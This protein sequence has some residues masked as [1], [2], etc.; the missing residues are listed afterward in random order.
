MFPRP[1]GSAFFSPSSVKS[2]P[3]PD[4][5]VSFR[6]AEEGIPS[7]LNGQVATAVGAIN[8]GAIAAI[9]G[10]STH[11][12]AD[13]Y[14]VAQSV[15]ELCNSAARELLTV[16]EGLE[17]TSRELMLAKTEISVQK[18]ELANK[19]LELSTKEAEIA[20]LKQERD[21][22]RTER[23]ASFAQWNKALTDFNTSQNQLKEEQ[24]RA[25]NYRTMLRNLR[26]E[27]ETFKQSESSPANRNPILAERR[28]RTRNPRDTSPHR[29]SERK[30]RPRHRSIGARSRNQ[31]FGQL[32][33]L[34]V[35][36]TAGG[37]PEH[38]SNHS[39]THSREE[40]SLPHTSTLP[41]GVGI[42]PRISPEDFARA[43]VVH[44]RADLSPFIVSLWI[45]VVRLRQELAIAFTADL[46]PVVGV[47]ASWVEEYV[48]YFLRIVDEAF[49]TRA[50]LFANLPLMPNFLHQAA[51]VSGVRLPHSAWEMA[52]S[53]LT[54]F[55]VSS[56]QS[57]LV[58]FLP[59]HV[60]GPSSH[61]ASSPGVFYRTHYRPE[62]I[63]EGEIR[64]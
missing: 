9:Q 25:E 50:A 53:N 40:R 28:S 27:F 11:I 14:L 62:T 18:I 52:Q 58:S 1:A 59:V 21:T 51:L 4:T 13:L 37:H 5:Q 6:P 8:N 2:E 34:A 20:K 22:A 31:S 39:L 42:D 26:Q 41:I 64:E 15:D 43:A 46:G 10:D 61:R 60:A 54:S 23:N 16:T 36:D 57:R 30:S 17:D 63:E 7:V 29:N 44:A 48:G 32:S 56:L 38:P 24:S 55:Q 33:G 47:L 45:Y 49:R 3:L 12:Q 35:P 19:D